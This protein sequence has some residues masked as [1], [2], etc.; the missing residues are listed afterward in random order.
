VKIILGLEFEVSFWAVFQDSDN[1]ITNSIIVVFEKGGVDG[2]VLNEVEDK[3]R[4]S[5]E[6][7]CK[8]KSAR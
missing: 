3:K 7:N 8:R 1:S 5:I 2:H 6:T 4:I